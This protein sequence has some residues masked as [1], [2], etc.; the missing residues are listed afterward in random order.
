MP[1]LNLPERL[2]LFLG[3]SLAEVPGNPQSVQLNSPT[4]I[5]VLQV[6]SCESLKDPG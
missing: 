1:K 4:Y 2:K 3:D 5:H 6:M